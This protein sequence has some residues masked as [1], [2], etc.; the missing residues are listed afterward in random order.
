MILEYVDLFGEGEKKRVK[1]EITTEHS[2][3]SYG[4]PVLVLDGG[5]VIDANS[6]V[7]LGYRIIRI[8]KRESVLMQKWLNHPP[9]Q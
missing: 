9:V 6:W 8:G 2:S 4:L 3:S 1:A 7:M 5:G